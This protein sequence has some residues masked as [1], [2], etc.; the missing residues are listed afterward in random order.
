MKHITLLSALLLMIGLNAFAQRYDRV[1]IQIPTDVEKRILNTLPVAADH[2]VLKDGTLTTDLRADEVEA[3]RAAG[4]QVEVLQEDM[5]AF[6]ARR[7]SASKGDVKAVEVDGCGPATVQVPAGFSLG[8]MAGFFTYDEFLWH[9]DNM[10]ATYPDLI[11]LRAPISSF[12]THEGRPIYWVRI[13]DNATVNEPEPEVLYTALH[14]ARE[15]VTLSQLIFYMYH[16]LESYGTDPA[17]TDLVNNTEMYL[18]PVLNPDGYIYNQ[19]TNPN[20]GGMWRKNRRNNGNGT[21]GVDLNRNYSVDWGGA[22]TSANGSSDVYKGPSPMSEPEIQAIEW[23][24]LQHSFVTAINFHS[25]ANQLLFPWGY[26]DAFQCADHNDYMAI[27]GAMVAENG[28]LN[29]QSSLLYPAAGDSDDWGYGETTERSA[30]YSMTCEIGGDNDGFWPTLDRIIPLCMENIHLNL[31]LARSATVHG[32]LTDR[33]P[34]ALSGG[35]HLRYDLT[36]AGWQQGTF[37]VSVEPL[38]GIAS[39][40]GVNQH[41]GMTIGQSLTD[42]IAFTLNAGITSGDPVRYVWVLDNGSYLMRDTI[43]RVFGQ[44][45]ILFANGGEPTTDWQGNSTWGLT[46]STFVSSPNSLTDSP[47]GDYPN[48]S[49]RYVDIAQPIDLTGLSTAVLRFHAKWAI[50]QGW[51]YAQVSARVNGTDWQPLCGNYTVTGNGNQDSG[52]PL[53]DGFQTTWVQEEMDL[54]AYLGQQVQIRFSLVSDQSVRE[55]GIYIDD[56]E[57]VGITSV[58]VGLAD[59]DRQTR[60]LWPN[61]TQGM[62]KFHTP[63]GGRFEVCDLAGREVA[64]GSCNLGITG[65]EFPPQAPSGIYLLQV[66]GEGRAMAPYRVVLMR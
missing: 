5:A 36:R 14:H 8:S 3:V 50:E 17:I 45:S 35:G 10:A 52:Q 23:F 19:T 9:L 59:S 15:A 64:A 60:G 26:T 41:N 42:S 46:T 2:G 61:P 18:V 31:T 48:S 21:F 53:Y 25:Y 11:T 20:G 16:L 49:N 62:L 51:D 40:G 39:V 34:L 66:I 12:Q 44:G 7:S 56:V 65:F 58:E 54:S 57:M 30:I 38:V 43:D 4:L 63:D 47:T 28:Y 33:Q 1:I 22:G 32:V 37:T 13:S 27:T 55:D 29:Q 24:A 6:Y